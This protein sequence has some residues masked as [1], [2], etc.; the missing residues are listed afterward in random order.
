[1]T[2]RAIVGSALLAAALLPAA[3]GCTN[4]DPTKGY[5]MVSPYPSDVKTVAVSIF[6]RGT[7]EYRRDI[8]IRLTEAIIDQIQAETPYK[9]VSRGRADTLLTGTLNSVRIQPLSSD[10]RTGLARE[11]QVRL[12]VDFL[13]QDLRG[14]GRERVRRDGFRVAAEYILPAPFSE[15]FFQGSESAI[16]RAALRIVEQLAQPW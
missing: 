12:D 15:D 6:R 7:G 9:V 13:W 1:M 2:A 11:I 3:T 8:E 5:T 10:S 14:A 16:N 4:T